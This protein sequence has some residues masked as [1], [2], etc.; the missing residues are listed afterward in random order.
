M[1]EN[2]CC[3]NDGTLQQSFANG[4]WW[5]P[6][7]L[8]IGRVLAPF[9]KAV[10]SNEKPFGKNS[11]TDKIFIVTAERDFEMEKEKLK[12]HLNVFFVGGKTKCT[13]HSL[14]FFVSLNPNERS[15]DM[16]KHID[17]HLIQFSV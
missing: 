6:P 16:Y 11:P 13:T 9:F 15:I 8:F 12:A 5:K 7:R 14:P 1:G 4:C 3:S 2:E 17:H 10:Y